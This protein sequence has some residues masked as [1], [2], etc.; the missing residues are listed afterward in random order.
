MTVL[1]VR[2]IREFAACC[3]GWCSTRPA[4]CGTIRWSE[5]LAAYADLR[6]DI[7]LMD[8]HMP[9]MDGLAA[10]GYSANSIR[11]LA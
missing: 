9:G 4:L 2:I 10:T 11:K 5:A 1:I 7:V 8:I 6:P 3:G